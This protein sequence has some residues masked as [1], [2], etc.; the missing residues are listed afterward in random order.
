MHPRT[1]TWTLAL[2]APGGA[3]SREPV[4]TKCKNAKLET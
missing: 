4:A 1:Y 2:R 3:F